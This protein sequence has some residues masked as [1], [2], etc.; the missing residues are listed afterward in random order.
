VRIAAV[1]WDI[2]GTL[3]DS[4]PLHHQAL[5]EASA[6]FYV[7]LG[8]L[9]PLAFRGVHM[10]DV[11]SRL[12]SRFPVTLTRAEWLDGIESRYIAGADRLRALAGAREAIERLDRVGIPQVCVS[13]SSRRIVDANL[14]TLGLLP[15][16]QFSI[17]LDDV[18]NGKPHPEPYTMAAQRLGIEPQR[19]LAVE[20][21]QSGLASA[22]AAGLRTVAIGRESADHA[23]W[24]ID[25]LTEVVDI[26]L[27][28]A[29]S[30]P[31][32]ARE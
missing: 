9:P 2:D 22:S 16:L 20:D 8:D 15:Y 17:S 4:E 11:W 7:D 26:V 18:A 10:E 13:N 3:V 1:A 31:G 23:D 24:Q 28:P 6:D 14:A 27:S 30:Q 25:S 19:L 5:L 32:E 21:S 12:Q 29:R